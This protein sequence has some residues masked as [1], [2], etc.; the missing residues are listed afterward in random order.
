MGPIFCSDTGPAERLTI[1]Q[2]VRMALLVVLETTT[3]AERVAL[4]L[5]H[6]LKCPQDALA[7]ICERPSP[8]FCV[9]PY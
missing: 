8:T 4:G 9:S 1:D 7:R 3:P 2:S 6:V 5:H